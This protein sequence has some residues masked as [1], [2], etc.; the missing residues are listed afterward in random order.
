MLKL[1]MVTS[2]QIKL[3]NLVLS[4]YLCDDMSM[5]QNEKTYSLCDKKEYKRDHPRFGY[6][7]IYMG[8]TPNLCVTTPPMKCLFG[9]QKTGSN[10]NM[11]LQ[12]TNLKED[13][14]MAFFYDFIQRIEFEC[15]KSIGLDENNADN[16]ISQIK[17]DKKG[18]YDPNL[19]IKVPFQKNS[20]QTEIF[21]DHSNEINLFNIQ[22]FTTMQ[23][24][25]YL[26]KI[27]RMNGKFYAKWKCKGIHL[28]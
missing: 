14:D 15:M 23:C 28:L 21:S 10:F 7:Q 11:S 18:L 17:H 12:F 22:N 8:R 2:D 9:V 4:P 5:K 16:F 3:E 1:K 13:S 26:D 24:D 6:L 25:I 20:F 19:S 27:W